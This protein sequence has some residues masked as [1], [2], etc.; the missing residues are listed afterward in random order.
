MSLAPFP[1]QQALARITMAYRNQS[2]IADRVLPRVPVPS[3]AFKYSKYT[4]ADAFTIPDTKVGRK[5]RPNEIDWTATETASATQDYG[6]DDLIPNF[7]VQQ[8]AANMVNNGVQAID[9]LARSTELL[10]QLVALDRE[11]RVAND[12]TSGVFTLGTYPAANRTTLAGTTQWSDF[13]N[14]DPV[15]AILTGLDTPLIRPNVMVIGQAAWSKLR[16]HPKISAAVYPMGGNATGGGTA[17][18]RQALA[19]LF[20]LEEVLVGQSFYNSAKPGQ[21]ATMA[22]LWGKHCALIYR[23]PNPAAQGGDATFGFTAQWGDRIGG[24]VET[25]AKVGL[26]G[27]VRV[28]VGESVK[29]IISANDVGYFFQNAV[30]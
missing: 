7:D 27:G 14:S 25:D 18:A 9:P 3:E 12:A 28:R 22:R 30:A 19:D 29:E 8:A 26:R 1:I 4:Q 13:T 16:T 17:V 5:S 23:S 6:L 10:N 20:E 21:T 2:F 15:Q 11:N 24:I